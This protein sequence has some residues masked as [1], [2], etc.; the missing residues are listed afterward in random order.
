MYKIKYNVLTCTDIQVITVY[1]IN[2]D[3]VPPKKFQILNEMME[4]HVLS[5][6]APMP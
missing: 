4:K 2:F 6:L 3:F 1:H 5:L